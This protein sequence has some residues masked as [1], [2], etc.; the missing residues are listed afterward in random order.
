MTTVSLA[1]A[2][3]CCGLDLDVAGRRA[4][5]AAAGLTIG[6]A[7]ALGVFFAA[8]EPWG[9]INDSLSIAL[10][11][12]TVPIAVQL[13]RREPPSRALSLGAA[14]DVVGVAV[15]TV[16]TTLL[17]SRRMTFEESLMPIMSG[18]SLIGTWL[19]LVGLSAWPDRRSRRA[20][21]SALLGGAGLVATNAGLATGGMGSP[22]AL[23]GFVAGLIGT[24]AFYAQLARRR[25]RP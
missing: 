1:D 9:T 3:S 17:I 15:I 20:A 16:F 24:T 11:W 10:A 5:G 12:A 13:T 6:A 23:A 8:G 14:C 22:V 25:S 7:I 18:Q 21:A 2:S 4:S 19:I